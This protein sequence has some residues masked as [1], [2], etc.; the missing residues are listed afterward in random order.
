VRI[1]IRA[2]EYVVTALMGTIT[3]LVIVE[4]ALRNLAGTSLIITDELSRYLMVWTAMLTATLLVY[5]DGHLRLTFLTDALPP[6]VA[7][8][9]YLV[10]ELVVLCFLALLV[11]ASL[12][13]MPSVREQNT[14]TLGVSMAW[15]YAALPIGGALMFGLT[16]R[17]TILRL[18]ARGK[19]G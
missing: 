9:V 7:R 13:L 18:T 4:I 14:V 2:L 17:G 19:S 15:F 11:V 16:L 1:L 5:E 12:M 6:L 3:L 10:S 8:A